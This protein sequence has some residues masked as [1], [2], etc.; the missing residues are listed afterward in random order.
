MNNK[1]NNRNGFVLTGAMV[2]WALGLVALSGTGAYVANKTFH[3][4]NG[5]NMHGMMQERGHGGRNSD[6][7]FITEHNE[8]TDMPLGD[9]SE[10]EREGLIL[11][12]EEEKLARDVY[13]TMYDLWNV[14]TFQNI[15]YS[16][17]R[18]SLAVKTLLDRY[19]IDD[20]V[21]DDTTGV[22]T[23]PAMRTLYTDLVAQGSTS[24]LDALRVGATIEDL[25]I[26]DLNKWIAS[27]DNE[28]ITMVYENLIRGSRNHMRSFNKQIVQ[29][30]DTYTA[31]YLTQAEINEI[32]AG[33]QERGNHDNKDS[34]NMRGQQGG[35]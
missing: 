14:K 6:H 24:L 26:Y 2:A 9:I 28:D 30:G 33:E 34:S 10:A 17:N 21:K 29:N 35:H 4:N 23:I 18:H 20:P 19:K 25:D 22:F 16:E 8:L 13:R 12:R 1:T 5:K 3:D 7:D 15:S 27:T 11:M 31:Q 32:L